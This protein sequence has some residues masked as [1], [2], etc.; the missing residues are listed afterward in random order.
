[1]IRLPKWAYRSDVVLHE[2]GHVLTPS[3]P[4]HG[5]DYAACYL[6]L[7]AMF[8]GREAE[9]YLREGYRREKVR[10]CKRRKVS[11]V[12]RAAMA[13][14]FLELRARGFAAKPGGSGA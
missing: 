9:V 4:G 12:M 7:V 8:L 14:R 11:P 10:Y 2:L 13:A 5:R 3:D 6:R 1:M